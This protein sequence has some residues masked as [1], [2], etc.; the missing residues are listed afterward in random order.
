MAITTHVL[1]SVNIDNA[2][3]GNDLVIAQITDFG[4]DTAIQELLLSADGIV[5]PTYT[6][7]AEQRPK[8]SLTSS[9]LATILAKA[10]IAGLA[11]AAAGA[12][13]GAD[14]YLKKVAAYGTRETGSNHVR[15]RIMN[16]FLLPRTLNAPHNQ[17]ATLGMDLIAIWDGTNNPIIIAGSQALVGSPVVSAVW[18]AG[19]VMINGVQLEGVQNIS[20]DFG[21]QEMVLGSDGNVWPT[22]CAIRERRPRITIRTLD[23]ISLSTFGLSGAAQTGTD[24][25]VYLRKMDKNGTRVADNVAEHIKFSIDDGVIQVRSVRG[26]HPNQFESEVTIIPTWDGSNAILVL[27]TAS[28][29]S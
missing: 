12:E 20:I 28:V 7:I 10:G 13:Y 17:V 26:S 16:G 4:V 22:Y 15:L 14:C 8:V 18:T 9:A 2:G 27:D 6:A 19:K 24:S 21:I 29:I 5:D 25:L 11:I 23:A 1:H 3:A